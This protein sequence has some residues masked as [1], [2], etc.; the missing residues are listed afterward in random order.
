MADLEIDNQYEFYK[1][2]R[3]DAAGNLLTTTTPTDLTLASVDY[4][5][6]INH[7]TT[8]GKNT[9]MITCDTGVESINGVVRLAGVYTF[10][11]NLSDTVAA[12]TVN[13]NSGRI[14]VDEL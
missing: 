8:A 11:P 6:A 5:D 2:V 3:L 1:A 13:A 9:V 12:I 7:V 10:Q 14:I 4:T